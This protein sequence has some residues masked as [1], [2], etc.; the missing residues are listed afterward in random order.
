MKTKEQATNF[1]ERNRDGLKWFKKNTVSYFGK[2]QARLIISPFLSRKGI[3][4]GQTIHFIREMIIFFLLS[5]P[6]H[7]PLHQTFVVLP[8]KDRTL[9]PEIQD[10]MRN[11]P[12]SINI[13]NSRIG[14]NTSFT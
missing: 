3:T 2:D 14:Q 12:D 8:F 13:R 5:D 1:L 9:R 7:N 10:S 11:E 4:A 6:P